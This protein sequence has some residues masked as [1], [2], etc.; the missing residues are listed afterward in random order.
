M[1]ISAL[2]TALTGLK[3][4]QQAL[5]TISSN[6]ANASTPG[7]TRKILPQ[8]SL[9]I[10]GVGS[11]VLTS[12]LVRNVDLALLRD[13]N[14]QISLTEAVSV[15][16]K[17]LDSIQDFHGASESE[18]AISSQLGK[19]ADGFASLSSAP[20]SPLYLNDVLNAAKQLASK[21]NDFGR[22]INQMRNQIQGEM[23]AGVTDAN[24]I[25]V[26]IAE[27]NNRITTLDSGDQSTAD[28]EDQRDIAVQELSKYIEITSYIGQNNQLVVM[29]KQGQLLVDSRARS[30]YFQSTN[31]TPNSYY[32]G[33]GANGVFLESP[34][35]FE[36]TANIGGSLGGLLELRDEN[37]PIY[38]AQV[39][40]LAQ[41]MAERFD[42]QGLRLFTDSNGNVPASVAPPAAVGY[43]GF[44][45]DI[46]VNQTIIND[47]TL[48]RRG[49]YGETIL[50][51]SNEV[52]NRVAKYAFGAFFAQEAT[53]SVDIS[54]GTLF[55]S[56][57][58]TQTNRLIGNMDLTDYTPDLDTAP[59]ITA[60]ATFTLTIGGVPQLITVAPGDTAT[61]L[62][63]DINTAFGSNVCALNGLG[64]L[65]FTTTSD[66]T[67]ANGTIGAAGMADLGFTFGTFPASNPALTIQVGTQSAVTVTI[68]PGDT[69]A[70]LLADLAAIPGLSAS[71]D[72]NGFLVLTPTL[73]GDLTISNAN[74]DPINTLGLTVS[75]VAHNSFRQSNLGPNAALSTGILGNSTL[76][77]FA[78]SMVSD[79]SE[80]HSFNKDNLE[81]ETSF[82]NTLS[83]RHSSQ[84]GVNIDEEL[85]E[86]IRV[87][88]AYTAAAKMISASEK[89]FDDL[90]AA[91]NF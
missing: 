13:L 85:S 9:V 84:T 90:M 57:G 31:L 3:A 51:G 77:D 34:S 87:Q 88:T 33:G 89:L 86:L 32:P 14:K 61:D 69:A 72:T 42:S 11:G 40:E 80:D 18:R 8:E 47:P 46:R 36:L 12:G 53:G 1:S 5:N 6:I 44:C 74:G 27:L 26:K 28:L 15:Q 49:T 66:I 38:Q 10:S 37:L 23:A 83:T 63:T 76:E 7:Y 78:R 91:F 60:P 82:L 29:T 50:E 81:K 25:M 35:G 70:D 67:I 68:A 19:L 22:T 24:Q 17:D 43:V 4:A 16:K 62:V 48:L 2:N 75:N 41:K 64:Q 21:F 71:L 59:N 55:A 65:S 20:N 39:D 58:M 79:Q 52:V 56:T 73:G 54:A 45:T 30:L